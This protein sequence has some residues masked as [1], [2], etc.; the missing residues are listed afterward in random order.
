MSFHNNWYNNWGKRKCGDNFVILVN[1]ILHSW[2]ISM[3]KSI[4]T[5]KFFLSPLSENKFYFPSNISTDSFQTPSPHKPPPPF[6]FS[7]SK[8]SP[9]RTK[10]PSE[11]NALHLKPNIE[12]IFWKTT[13]VLPFPSCV[14]MAFTA[15]VQPHVVWETT[16]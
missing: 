15:I 1:Y 4:S 2:R 3:G 12:N 5:Y 9:L 6:R 11:H 8:N 7:P 16:L 14:F 13:T 10:M